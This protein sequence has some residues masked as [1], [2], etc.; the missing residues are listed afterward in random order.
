MGRVV[1]KV[2]AKSERVSQNPSQ[3]AT[4]TRERRT[5]V[6]STGEDSRGV[7]ASALK[8]E[9]TIIDQLNLLA[10]TALRAE[11]IEIV[12]KSKYDSESLAQVYFALS[13]LF[14]STTDEDVLE[15]AKKALQIFNKPTSALMAIAN[16]SDRF[17][18]E[19]GL[20]EKLTDWSKNLSQGLSKDQLADA[21][22]ELEHI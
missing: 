5:A 13:H 11:I 19:P 2:V 16:L 20:R 8:A 9:D 21:I 14:E 18:E 3:R 6:E 22:E 17:I 15:V 10:T 4:R 12:T 7:A 1:T